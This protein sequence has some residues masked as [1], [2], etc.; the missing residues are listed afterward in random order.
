M[1]YNRTSWSSWVQF[2]REALLSPSH[3]TKAAGLQMKRKKIFSRFDEIMV[4]F[5]F[6]ALVVLWFFREPGFMP[7]W[8][9]GFPDG[10]VHV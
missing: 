3:H 2:K 4:A 10:Q 9:G 6:G 1:H 7:G 8:A 5:L